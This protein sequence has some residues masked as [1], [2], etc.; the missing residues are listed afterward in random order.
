[1]SDDSLI[2][3]DE[4]A[5][6]A[7]A[8]VGGDGR[9]DHGLM[10]LR[11]GGAIYVYA[12][13]CPH[14]SLPLDFKPGEFLDPDGELIQCSNHGAQ[15]QVEDGVCVFGPCMGRDLEPVTVEVRDGA[16]YRVG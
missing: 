4:I 8:R 5:D 13:R 9:T 14:L 1:M 11:R 2:R 7:S 15:F 16:V 6:G 3:L 10:I 12:N